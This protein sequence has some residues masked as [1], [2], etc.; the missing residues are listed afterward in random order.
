MSKAALVNSVTM[1]IALWIWR[2]T[3]EASENFSWAKICLSHH[4]S[5]LLH[6]VC[7]A[8]PKTMTYTLK[9]HLKWTL[10]FS[11]RRYLHTLSSSAALRWPSV[12]NMTI[13]SLTIITISSCVVIKWPSVANMTIR[14]LTIITVSSYVV[15]R[16]PIWDWHDHLVTNYNYHCFLC[17]HVVL[18]GWQDHLITN[19]NYF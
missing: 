8:C 10:D 2:S 11:I 13:R 12:V 17:R 15:I 16:W 4:I 9:A 5:N 19:Y 14:S 7:V 3:V 6:S 1:Q 18:C